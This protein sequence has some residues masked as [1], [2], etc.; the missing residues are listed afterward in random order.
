VIPE[1]LFHEAGASRKR[2]ALPP[3]NSI[4]PAPAMWARLIIRSPQATEFQL[5]VFVELAGGRQIKSG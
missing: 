2:M 3:P 4:T 1:F 5:H